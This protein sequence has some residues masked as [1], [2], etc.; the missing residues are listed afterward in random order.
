MEAEQDH[1]KPIEHSGKNRIAVLPFVNMSSDTENEYFSDGITEEIINALTKVEGLQVIGRTSAFSFKGQD[2]D[3]RIIGAKLKV[4]YILEGSVRKSGNRVRVTA[5]LIKSEDGFHI[6]SEVYDRELKDIFDVQ[7]DISN[8]I[9]RRFTESFGVWED[10]RNLVES[11]T[12]NFKAYDLYLRGRFNLGKGS[13]EAV[14]SAIHYFE[15]ALKKDRNFV[16]PLAGLAACYTFLG[17]SGLMRPEQAFTLAREYANKTISLDEELAE[18]HLALANSSFWHDWD[19]ENTGISIRKAIR[20]SPGTASIHIFNSVYLMAIGKLEE[21]YI[22]AQLAAKL[23]P[24]S[25]KARFAL[26]EVHYRSERFPEAIEIFERVLD[27]NPFFKQAGILKAWCHYF[28]GEI[29]AAREL[30]RNIAITAENSI[31]FYGGLAMTYQ[32]RNQVDR[33]IDCLKS[34]N[35]EVKK[36]YEHWLSYNYTL[37]YRALGETER[38]YD[39]LEK[40]LTEKVTPLIFIQVAPLW[41]EYHTD[42]R[43]VDLIEKTFIQGKKDRWIIL[44]SDTREKLEL[45][46]STLIYIEAQENYSRIVWLSG[47]KVDEKLLRV[48]LKKIENQVSDSSIIRC[49]KSYIINTGFRFNV[50]G[51]SNGYRLKS[52]YLKETIPVS[53][54]LG[55]EVV[56]KIRKD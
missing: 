23:D 41:K 53:R 27:E 52:S 10:H 2:I 7:D 3:L 21:A 8:K 1:S 44:N 14:N 43:F 22:E 20:L 19:F 11:K 47:D 28:M 25:L 26:G 32:V 42:A 13:L 5:Q 39:L 55:K 56:A 51:N 15:S 33:V 9:V 29:Q 46:L 38:M 6:F 37:I 45:N 50:L 18:S 36:G 31:T 34:F 12:D 40:S 16:L 54:S 30:F 4:L 35:D 48:T 17:G 49:H 24:L